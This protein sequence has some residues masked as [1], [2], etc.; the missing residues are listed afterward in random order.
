MASGGIPT[1]DGWRFTRVEVVVEAY[2][3][4]LARELQT[5]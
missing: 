5:T 4:S 3:N 1:W 2:G